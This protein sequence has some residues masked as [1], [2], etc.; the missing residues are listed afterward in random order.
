MF[1][2]GQ[3]SFGQANY[4]RLSELGEVQ[5]R[6]LGEYWVR[7][8]EPL[9]AVYAGTLERQRMTAILTGEAFVGKGLPFPE[10]I[11]L[12]ELNEYDTQ[13]ILSSS[14]PRA[15]SE[16]PEILS[17]V[18]ELAPAGPE[19]LRNNKR[20]FQRLFARVMDLW[21]EGRLEV[22]GMESWPEFAAR[23]N[24]GLE[25]IMAEQ[26]SGRT[27][28]VFTSGGPISA[29]MQRALNCPDKTALELGWMI[30]NGSITEFKFKDG[31]FTLAA[32]NS[33]PHLVEKK[34]WSY[35]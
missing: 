1:R 7:W 32:F 3:A 5:A 6:V 27:V 12:P 4:D 34:L 16:H 8:R 19:A 31:R 23:V 15:V 2:H 18:K 20:A 11:E 9:D 13:F 25:R 17:L 24:R 30:L 14:V 33:A 21:V 22:E 26:S 10:I 35:R 29:A 28:G